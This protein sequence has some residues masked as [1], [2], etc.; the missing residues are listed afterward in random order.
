MAKFI[1]YIKDHIKPISIKYVKKIN[2]QHVKVPYLLNNIA[3]LKIK[4]LIIWN[5]LGKFT[6]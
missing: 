1:Y 5:I 3:F 6:L 4:K 2:K